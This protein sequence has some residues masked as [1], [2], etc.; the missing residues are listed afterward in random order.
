M[1]MGNPKKGGL[2]RHD[3][4]RGKFP[5]CWLFSKVVILVWGSTSLFLRQHVLPRA[6]AATSQVVHWQLKVGGSKVM[7]TR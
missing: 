5:S 2:S 7:T 6:T 3:G 4:G 1:Y